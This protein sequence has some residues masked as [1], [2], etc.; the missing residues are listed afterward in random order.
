M[1]GTV[2]KPSLA[3]SASSAQV[4]K[5]YTSGVTSVSQLLPLRSAST[6]KL[7]GAF[8]TPLPRATAPRLVAAGMTYSKLSFESYQIYSSTFLLYSVFYFQRRKERRQ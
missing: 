2:N 5:G 1:G 8:P 4:N 3:S 6:I 7:S